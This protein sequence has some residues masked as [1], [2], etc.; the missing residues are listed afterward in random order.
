MSRSLK[1]WVSSSWTSTDFYGDRTGDSVYFCYYGWLFSFWLI[2]VAKKPLSVSLIDNFIIYTNSHRSC[3]GL[4]PIHCYLDGCWL[5]TYLDMK[6]YYVEYGWW[7]ISCCASCSTWWPVGRTPQSTGP[8]CCSSCCWWRL[9]VKVPKFLSHWWNL[10]PFWTASW[11]RHSWCSHHHRCP[12]AWRLFW[13]LPW[14]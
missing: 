7:G 10:L 8:H 13:C 12:D 1:E 4:S 14:S 6:S 11:V 3:L 5:M 2:C 9:S